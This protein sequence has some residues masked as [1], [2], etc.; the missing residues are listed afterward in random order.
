MRPPII[1]KVSRYDVATDFVSRTK[2]CQN[3]V[4]DRCTAASKLIYSKKQE[5]QMRLDQKTAFC[6]MEWNNTFSSNSLFVKMR[7]S[8]IQ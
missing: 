2:L 6:K 3:V 1:A 7:H 4:K 5:T 8:A